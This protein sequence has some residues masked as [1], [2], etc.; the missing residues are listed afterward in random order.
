MFSTVSLL[1]F[2]QKKN[3]QTKV[4]FGKGVQFISEDS[5]FTLAINGRIQSLFEGKVDLDK[6]TFGADF[7]IRRSRLNFQGTAL[8]P[9]FTY[10]IQIGFAHGDITSGNSEVE[11]NL[12]LRDAMLYYQAKKWLKIGYGQTKLPGNRQRQISSANLQLVER[13]IVNNNFTLDRDKGIWFYTNFKIKKAILKPTF[14]VSSGDGRIVSNKNGKLSYTVRTELLP[15]GEFKNN[16]DYIESAQEWEDKPK[17]AIAGVYSFNQASNR[18]MGQLGN[19]LYN[20]TTSD[21]KYYGGDIYFKHKRFS[22][23]SELYTRKS[24][25]AII[26]NAQDKNLKNYVISG[27]GLMFQSGYFLTKKDEIALRYAQVTPNK[28]LES[29]MIKQKEHVVGYSHYFYKHSLKLQSDATY[30][31]NGQNGSLIFRLSSVVSF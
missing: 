5:L 30:L 1:T 8:S 22:F 16:G 23:E 14:A 4:S 3:T 26:V 2:S 24:N 20:S 17:L 12:I 18:T 29:I 27:T 13:S 25:T 15:L 10:R 19:F 6:K 7:M 21:I 9:K 28:K 31:K 11:N